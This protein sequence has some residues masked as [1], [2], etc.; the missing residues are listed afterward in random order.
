MRGGGWGI[1][2]LGQFTLPFPLETSALQKF[3]V[4][5]LRQ[6]GTFFAIMN[7]QISG[8][9]TA[10]SSH[11][12]HPIILIRPLRSSIF[13]TIIA[14]GGLVGTFRTGT[15]LFNKI[16]LVFFEILRIKTLSFN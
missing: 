12:I 7:T 9:Q 8:I 6:V 15:I 10:S 2:N 1:L 4:V 14:H 13:N 11:G 5:K 16:N 3:K